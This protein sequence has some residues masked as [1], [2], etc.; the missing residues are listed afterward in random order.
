M[1]NK[2]TTL[3]HYFA[4]ETSNFITHGFLVF[5]RL[6]IVLINVRTFFYKYK[7]IPT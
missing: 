2:V 7:N 6:E 3:Q 5:K 1:K 4:N